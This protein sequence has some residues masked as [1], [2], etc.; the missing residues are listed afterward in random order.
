[1]VFNYLVIT[2]QRRMTGSGAAVIKC[3][4]PKTQYQLLNQLIDSMGLD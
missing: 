2:P 4:V 3:S 1:M